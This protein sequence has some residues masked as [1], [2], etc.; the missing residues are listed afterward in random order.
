MRNFPVTKEGN[1][2]IWTNELQTKPSGTRFDAHRE[3]V[4]IKRLVL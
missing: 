2:L 1:K 4:K 3:Q